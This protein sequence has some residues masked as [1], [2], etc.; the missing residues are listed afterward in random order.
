MCAIRVVRT[1]VFPVPAPARTIGRGTLALR[2]EVRQ[3]LEPLRQ[4]AREDCWAG[5]W[6][7][8]GRAPVLTGDAVFDLRFAQRLGQNFTMMAVGRKTGRSAVLLRL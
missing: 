8:F 4:L 2:P 6:L 7:Q 3:P 1:R 5:A